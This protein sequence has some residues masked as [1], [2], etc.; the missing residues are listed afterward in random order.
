MISALSFAAVNTPVDGA[1]SAGAVLLVP[2]GTLTTSKYTRDAEMSYYLSG[3]TLPDNEKGL[4]VPLTNVKVDNEY[5][6]KILTHFPPPDYTAYDSENPQV[7]RL[8]F[9][10]PSNP[11]WHGA[12]VQLLLF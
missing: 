3:I 12:H 7:S 5:N 11:P 9:F 6:L 8:L 10:D 1:P 2:P 4:S